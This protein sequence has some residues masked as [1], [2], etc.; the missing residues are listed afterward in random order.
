MYT[1][2]NPVITKRQLLIN[3]R[4]LDCRVSDSWSLWWCSFSGHLQASGRWR[5]LESAAALFAATQVQRE[6]TKTRPLCPHGASGYCPFNGFH[7]TVHPDST[8]QTPETGQKTAEGQG[9]QFSEWEKNTKTVGRPREVQWTNRRLKTKKKK[10]Y[11]T[12]RVF[13]I[14]QETARQSS[15]THPMLE[16]KPQVSPNH[17]ISSEHMKIALLKIKMD[18]WWLQQTGLI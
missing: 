15:D 4:K 9:D 7:S 10:S 14:H 12:K 8:P 11:K 2:Y 16:M 5:F 1:H 13:P 6:H 3:H 17:N 18:V